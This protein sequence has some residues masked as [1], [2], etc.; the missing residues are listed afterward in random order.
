MNDYEKKPT[1][2][3]VVSGG[4]IQDV[5]CDGTAIVNIVDYDNNED[6]NDATIY[7]F[8]KGKEK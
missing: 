5:K 4:V 8:C 1:I 6:G 7:E 2:V 3:I